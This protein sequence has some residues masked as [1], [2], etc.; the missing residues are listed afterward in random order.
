MEQLCRSH[1]AA[2][3]AIQ[4]P[5]PPL[6]DLSMLPH[7]HQAWLPSALTELDT[8]LSQKGGIDTS[9]NWKPQQGVDALW[10]YVANLK[11]AAAML[12]DFVP[13]FWFC[14][15]SWKHWKIPNHTN[16]WSCQTTAITW[17]KSE[18]T[19]LQKRWGEKIMHLQMPSCSMPSEWRPHKWP[20]IPASGFSGFLSGSITSSV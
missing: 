19:Q 7:T 4:K 15:K 5:L 17:K 1:A 3:A 16:I 10:A 14:L 18:N 9:C 13:T 6:A 2:T 12:L 8:C 11:E 20:T